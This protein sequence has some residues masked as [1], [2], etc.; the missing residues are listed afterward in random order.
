MGRSAG[1]VGGGVASESLENVVPPVVP[2]VHQSRCMTYERFGSELDDDLLA[3]CRPCHDL[4]HDLYSHVSREMTVLFLADYQ[5]AEPF[6]SLWPQPKIRKWRRGEPLS[7]RCV[8]SLR[9]PGI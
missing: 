1:S 2:T 4:L 5:V 8:E 3:L 7:T 6:L 9:E